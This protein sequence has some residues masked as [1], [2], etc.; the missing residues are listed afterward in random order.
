MKDTGIGILENEHDK[1]FSIFFRGNNELNITAEGKGVGLA[2][3]KTLLENM[4]GEIWVESEINRGST[5]YFTIPII[6]SQKEIITD[7][8][9]IEKNINH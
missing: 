7:D 1:I 6:H 4:D 8:D 2:M 5:F 3:I 9:R